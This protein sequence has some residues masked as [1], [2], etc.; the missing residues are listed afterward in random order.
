M[1]RVVV[2]LSAYVLVVVG[3]S[4]ESGRDHA[5]TPEDPWVIGM[6]QFNLGEPW[7][8]QMD[9]DVRSAA[10]EHPNSQAN[11]Q[12]RNKPFPATCPL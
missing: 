7:R 12:Q 5:G 2:L 11:D 8:V 3:C 9:A 1:P 6:S 10:A 4:P